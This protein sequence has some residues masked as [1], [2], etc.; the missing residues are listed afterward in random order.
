M[1]LITSQILL[2]VYDF[3]M[4][5]IVIYNKKC[6]FVLPPHSWHTACKPLK[7]PK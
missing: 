4:C 1:S 5:D 2:V 7:F 3:L 6:V